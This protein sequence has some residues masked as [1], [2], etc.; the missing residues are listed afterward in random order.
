[1]LVAHYIGPAKSGLVARI[2]WEITVLGQKGPYDRCT[3]TEAIHAVHADGTVDI[4]SSSLVD[5]G[6]RIKKR[7]RLTPGNWIITDVPAFDLAKSVRW[8]EEA[9]DKGV[10]YDKRGAL[11]TLLP[12]KQS[13]DKAYCTECVLAPFIPE[14][15]Y[16][17]PA[18]CLALC[19][20]LGRV[21]TL[22]PSA[23]V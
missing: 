8:F 21:V 11:S 16:F 14:S 17:T 6:V 5:K 19:M 9:I 12:G 18:A 23:S 10:Q 7:V 20:G 13:A 2:G 4:A 1:M 22:T 3:H 15:H